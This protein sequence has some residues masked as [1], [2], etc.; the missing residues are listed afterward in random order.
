MM[1]LRRIA[2][3]KRAHR[4]HAFP[5]RDRHELGFV[6]AIFAQRLHPERFFE[7]RFDAG[8][9]V[10]GFVSVGPFSRSAPPPDPRDCRRRLLITHEPEETRKAS[11]RKWA[12]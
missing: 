1:D 7:Q 10:V 11:S 9:V 6:A 8:F 2:A 12:V 5:I 4:F 3:G